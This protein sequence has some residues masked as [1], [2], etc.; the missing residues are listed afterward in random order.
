MIL[1]A[2]GKGFIGSHVA[3]VFDGLDT[4]LYDIVDLKDGQDVCDLKD[5]SKYDV[6]VLV[7]ANLG[8]DMDMF[9]DNLAIY[10]WAARQSAHIIYTSSAAVYADSVQPHSE[11]EPTPAPTIYGRSKLLGEQIISQA[12]PNRTI[13]RLGNVYG[14]GEGN[15][16]ID[17]FKRG[18]STIY[19]MGTDIRDY[20]HVKWVAE[21][22]K[23]IAL[24]P[25][26]YNKEIY[27]ISSGI[28]RTT[29]QMFDEFATAEVGN[30]VPARGFD[31]ECSILNN[32]KAVNA[33]LINAD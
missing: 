2:G 3:K 32:R 13:L 25:A 16:V 6:I 8:H 33:G 14:D 15:G 12:C 17:I 28:G 9:Q 19:G 26:K 4:G 23:T 27:N 18:G 24:N 5:T 11:G 22:I 10:R 7:A 1:I 29:N 20:I 21:A 31:V 30:Y